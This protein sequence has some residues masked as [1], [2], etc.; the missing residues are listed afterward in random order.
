MTDDR[1]SLRYKGVGR[2]TFLK[3]L[4]SAGPAA[5]LAACSVP[6]EHII[7]YVVPPEQGIPGVA[8]WYASVCGECP[9]G[10]G[11]L[12]RTREGRP[13]KIEGNPQH[14][15]NR[16]ALCVRGQASLQGLYDPDRIP[17]PR[18]RR[19]TSDRGDRAMDPVAWDEAQTLIVERIASLRQQG[20]ADRI[21]VVTGAVSG[22]LDA[23]VDRWVA[24]IGAG[25]RLRYEPFAYEAMRAANRLTFGREAIPA[26]ELGR[27]DLLL[28]FGADFLETWL[29]TVGY[30]RDFADRR[31]LNGRL[32][33]R[34][35]HVEPR[36]S[37]T[38]AR[39]DEWIAAVPGTE[40]L[41]ALAM[42]HVILAEGLAQ[43]LTK[44]EATAISAL[45]DEYTPAGV[46]GPTDV[47]AARIGAIARAFSD[48]AAGP[49][50]SLA[51]A[52]GV[53]SSGTNATLTQA[54]VNLLNYVAG[55]VGQTVNFGANASFGRLHPYRDM[56]ALIEAMR[57][58]DI[59]LLILHGV[60]AAFSMPPGAGFAE[61]IGRVPFVVSCSSFPDETAA[62]AHLVLPVHTPLEAWGD[63]EPRAGVRGLRQPTVTPLL[64]SRHFGDLLLDVGRA[65]GDDVSDALPSGDF[66]SHLRSEWQTLQKRA[67]PLEDFE[68]FWEAA[69]KRGGYW[70]TA[71]AQPVRLAPEFFGTRFETAT[72]A[73]ADRPYTLVV[74]PSL[75]HYDGRGANKP[76]LQEIPE[77]MTKAGWTT[78]AEIHP[79]A[80]ARLG[81]SDGQLVTVES[82][83]GTLDLP[84]LLNP[85]VRSDVVAI[86]L[87]Q[88]HAAYGRYA[89]NRGQN[90]IALL[91]H[92]A[93]PQSGGLPWL[94]T[95]VSVTARALF[96]P[97]PRTQ[98]GVDQLG[99][100]IAQ[101]VTIGELRAGPARD[102]RG[103]EHHSLNPEH[104]HRDH[105]W[106]MAI[107]LDSC[108]GCNACVAACYAENNVP[109][110]G[111]DQMARGRHMAWLRLDRFD[112]PVGDRP[113]TRFV[114]MLCQHCDH[115]PCE[116]VCPVY[117]TYH[118]EEGLNAQ[119]YNRCVGTRYCANNCPYKV[120]RFNWFEP[121]FAGSLTLQL[122]P[123]VT[124]RSKGV[125]EKCTFCVQR[126]Q[127]SKGHAK[128]DGRA[129]RD[130]DV[131]PACA[132][133]CPAQAIVF[134]DLRDP[135]SRV[136][137]LA[138]DPRSYQVFHEL[139]TRPAISYLKKVTRDA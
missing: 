131:T 7:P 112:E 96:R 80:A 8:A 114:P 36:R 14:P 136:S 92:A 67:A 135:N 123:D 64:D 19:A 111:P 117:A 48:P 98:V 25:R 73:A 91:P 108:T 42:V 106:G 89:E 100:G 16:G 139:N 38:A 61:A 107:D 41:L 74:Y 28:S 12:V 26:Y 94:A 78:W 59:E 76:W 31:R 56:L 35:I 133:T 10:C 9:A 23:L 6:T 87:G 53:A 22:T 65:A 84:A 55:N 81:V 101:A 113:D 132:Q 95:R 45:V 119:V 138:A 71:T 85:H 72:L 34:F 54:A 51:I 63:E 121:A 68:A 82:P 105:R 21:A 13:I 11:T 86:P 109:L 58:G 20:R 137:R 93:E 33:A 77:P 90:P 99:R 118:N 60:N 125:M 24:A 27:A 39:A 75:Q 79:D 37:M 127:E 128:D 44:A 129:M 1:T 103:D 115:A 69:Q 46:A 124:V 104:E 102:A 17:G 122:N 40:V 43:G 126:I 110:V 52:G 47:P 18:R 70:E 32:P 120:R 88:G 97:I 2:R 5:A 130:G 49:G 83:E 3:M 116:T 15:V 4:G 29:S 62:L 134:G 30:S 57:R 66:F 50:R